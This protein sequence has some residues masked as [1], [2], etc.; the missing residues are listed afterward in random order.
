MLGLWVR[1]DR[2]GKKMMMQSICK[3]LIPKDKMFS[4]FDVAEESVFKGSSL[5]AS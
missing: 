3:L 1:K 4:Y 5:T 2:N